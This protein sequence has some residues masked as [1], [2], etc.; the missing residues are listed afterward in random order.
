[1]NEAREREPITKA[2]VTMIANNL[3]LGAIILDLHLTDYSRGAMQVGDHE[4]CFWLTDGRRVDISMGAGG[5]IASITREPDPNIPEPLT[6]DNN[7][8]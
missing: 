1:M 7:N 4:K 5:F 8:V 6:G 3:G 2:I